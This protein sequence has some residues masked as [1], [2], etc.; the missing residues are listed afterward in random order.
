MS[1]PS[2]QRAPDTTRIHRGEE[3]SL[4]PF[5]LLRQLGRGGFAPVWLAE[6]T[7]DGRKLRD[8]AVKLFQPPDAIAGGSVEEARWRDRIIDE[9]HALCRVEHPNVVR[10]YSLHR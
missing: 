6:Q 9:A 1:L 5:R 2:S 8:V 3:M 10:F 4:G 7:Y